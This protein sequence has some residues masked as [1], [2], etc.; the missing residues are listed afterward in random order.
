MSTDTTPAAGAVSPAT[1][2]PLDDVMI[3]MDMV[4]L[5]RREEQIIARELNVAGEEEA[6]I[7][8]MKEIYAAQGIDVTDDV[9]RGGLEAARRDR[10][11]YEPAPPGWQRWL[12]EI[13]IDRGR[14]LLRLGTLA[15]I[16]GLLWGA[17]W[18]FV[19]G[20]RR[21]VLRDTPVQIAEAS[22]AITRE[23]KVDGPADKAKQL[24]DEARGLLQAGQVRESRQKLQELQELRRLV[25]SEYELRIVAQGS[26]GVF[27]EPKINQ[28][29]MNYYI[30]VEAVT[31]D[32]TRL[33]LPIKS[34]ETNLTSLV[35][36]WGLRV[37]EFTFQ[38]V[39][40]DKKDDGII[41]NNRFGQKKRGYLEPEFLV[42]STGGA[43]TAW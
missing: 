24:A 17:Y 33:T 10:F 30:I 26:T 22:D 1:E 18:M 34:E 15:V 12:A 2:P 36:K 40:N 29:S 16:G 25:E 20:P 7:K 23:S 8:R 27:R 13:Y 11:K 19:E 4:D 32:N 6:L 39:E 14:W 35:S 42:P 28:G 31:P 3:A 38:Q 37:D 9:L 41:Q 43:I 5:L 21:Q